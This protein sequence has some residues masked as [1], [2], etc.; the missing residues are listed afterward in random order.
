MTDNFWKLK[1]I[2]YNIVIHGRSGLV[3]DAI[4]QTYMRDN[5]TSFRKADMYHDEAYL[6]KREGKLFS[7]LIAARSLSQLANHITS[8]FLDEE[9]RIPKRTFYINQDASIDTPWSAKARYLQSK[10]VQNAHLADLLPESSN[11]LQTQPLNQLNL[12]K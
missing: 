9:V 11:D 5:I 6:R 3:Q 12:V 10:S 7:L 4:A 1:N 2:V 8:K